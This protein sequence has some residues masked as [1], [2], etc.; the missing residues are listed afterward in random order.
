MEEYNGKQTTNDL[1]KRLETTEP[2]IRRHFIAGL[3]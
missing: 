2:K 3:T 1:N